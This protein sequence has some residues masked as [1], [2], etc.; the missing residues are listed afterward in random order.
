M[1][2]PDGTPSQL[3]LRSPQGVPSSRA[4]EALATASHD[5][6]VSPDAAA[7]RAY[8]AAFYAVSALFALS[9]RT[10]SK[11]SAVEAA[12][13]RDLVKRGKWQAELGKDYSQLVGLRETGDYGGGQ[14]VP[15]EDAKDAVARARRILEAVR[16]AGGAVFQEPGR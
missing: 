8:Y 15:A 7:S 14:H 5:L 10:F 11:H 1:R 9:D 4:R 12:V 2:R 3:V 16:Q 13:H 6:P